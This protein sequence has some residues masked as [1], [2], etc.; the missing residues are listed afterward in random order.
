MMRLEEVL[1]ELEDMEIMEAVLLD[2]HGN[3]VGVYS[4][5]KIRCTLPGYCKAT[6]F[7]I[8]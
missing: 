4:I 1:A 7:F 8:I 5:D 2:L 3:I 6:F